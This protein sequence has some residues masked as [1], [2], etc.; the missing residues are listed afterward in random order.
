MA[1]ASTSGWSAVKTTSCCGPCATRPV[2]LPLP[3]IRRSLP[4][5]QVAPQPERG[6]A[7]GAPG[8]R[9]GRQGR[10][11]QGGGQEGRAGRCP[12]H[13]EPVSQEPALNRSLPDFAMPNSAA[14][15][16]SPA[17]KPAKATVVRRREPAAVPTD[18]ALRIGVSARLLHQAP[19]ELGFR[20]RS[21]STS[22]SRWPTGS[23]STGRWPSW[24]RPWRTTA[25]TRRAISR[26]SRWCRSW[27]PWCCR[28]APTWRPELRA[29]PDGPT[30]AG[31]RGARPL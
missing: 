26:W 27:M 5:G 25:N 20:T 28:V 6:R 24:C 11:A 9:H 31:R 15:T 21:C 8:A 14:L 13:R 1:D 18:R 2:C 12:Q 7:A 4:G 10:R 22:N 23:W 30:L 17:A 29:D 3:T 16:K 19:Q